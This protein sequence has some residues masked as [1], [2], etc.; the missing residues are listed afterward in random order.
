M[1]KNTI[2]FVFCPDEDV[3]SIREHPID[4]FVLVTN[5]KVAFNPPPCKNHV[6]TRKMELNCKK[7]MQSCSIVQPKI[8]RR[9]EL[10][11]CGVLFLR[12]F[13]SSSCRSTRRSSMP[14]CLYLDM[15]HLDKHNHFFNTDKIFFCGCLA[16]F[17]F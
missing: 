11:D 4:T 1:S 17:L 9:H 10:C 6:N 8:N 5:D 13:P 15:R 2:A 3:P 12:L 14:L 16:L 7:Q